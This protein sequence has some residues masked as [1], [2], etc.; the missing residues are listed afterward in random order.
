[1]TKS[2]GQNKKSSR[3]S[4]AKKQSSDSGFFRFIF[5]PG[6]WIAILVIATA[7]LIYW[8][9]PDIVYWWEGFWH[10]A[11]QLFGL[12]LLLLLILNTVSTVEHSF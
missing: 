9:L 3:R 11:T 8:F 2:T 5:S 4:S 12:G 10:D 1:M 6:F 7:V